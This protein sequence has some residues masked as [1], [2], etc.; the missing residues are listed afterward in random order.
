MSDLAALVHSDGPAE[1]EMLRQGGAEELFPRGGHMVRWIVIETGDTCE[2][3]RAAQRPVRGP[4]L[5]A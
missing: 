4:R 3:V 2:G 5:S 1:C